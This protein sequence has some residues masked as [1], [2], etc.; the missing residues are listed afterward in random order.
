MIFKQP[1]EGSNHSSKHGISLAVM[2]TMPIDSRAKK[3][4]R[5]KWSGR[6]PHRDRV[7]LA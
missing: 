2:N 3:C 6:Y 7:S 1:D 4:R 5:Y